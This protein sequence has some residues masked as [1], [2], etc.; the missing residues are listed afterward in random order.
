ME[1]A[2]TIEPILLL[3]PQESI[4]E[5]KRF[6]LSTPLRASAFPVLS[7]SLPYPACNPILS[8][9]SFFPNFCKMDS[10]NNHNAIKNRCNTF[11]KGFESIKGYAWD[12]G[13]SKKP[14]KKGMDEVL[15][16]SP[17]KIV[18]D[19]EIQ[20]SYLYMLAEVFQDT[21]AMK[22]L[23]TKHDSML[24]PAGRE[25]L[26]FWEQNPAFWC[27]FSVKEN[28][29]GNFHQIVDHMS[30]KEHLL[31][32][33]G[34]TTM[35]KWK[36]AEGLSFLCLMQPNGECLQTV[37][38]IKY[39]RLPASDVLFY[40]AQFKPEEGLKDILHKHF[41]QFFT[42]DTI[43]YAPPLKRGIYKMGFAW[44]AFTLPEFSL[45]NLGGTWF[46]P[47]VGTH[48]KF[49][50]KTVDTRMLGLPNLAVFETEPHAMAGAIIRDNATDEMALLTN[51]EV[52]YSFFSALLSRAYPTIKLPKEPSIFIG[53]PMQVLLASLDLPVPWKKFEDII[54]YRE[55]KEKVE[56]DQRKEWEKLR[57]ENR[58]AYGPD[59][60]DNSERDL[61]DLFIEAQ[62]TGKPLD[63]DKVSKVMGLDRQD[64]QRLLGKFDD[65]P[66]GADFDASD[67]EEDFDFS[68][69]DFDESYEDI[70]FTVPDEDKVFELKTWPMPT[71][72]YG[73]GVYQSLS[74]S[75]F[76]ESNDAEEAYRQFLQL[77]GKNFATE[78]GKDGLFEMVE[79]L[80]S[81]TFYENFAYPVMN[82][83]FWI[84]YHEGKEW[85][86]VRSY[87]IEILKWIPSDILH[88]YGDQEV[89]IELLGKFIK[90]ML[91]TRGICSLAK[92][93]SSEEIRSGTYAIKATDAFYSLLKVKEE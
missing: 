78:V 66:E 9:L 20:L 2:Y 49:T 37:G 6:R 38:V 19:N 62:I 64:V 14:I 5:S 55:P 33:K 23:R 54:D 47:T 87:A 88:S 44:Q 79:A 17:D 72:T 29:G 28:L 41:T 60:S 31:Y 58:K 11:T 40:C 24:T 71:D 75:E 76:F 57:E 50:L 48:Q 39:Y 45:E 21:K 26:S 32:S 77:G 63:A 68:D 90:R 18:T 73:D 27:Y 7:I 1:T 4:L 13:H 8:P 36:E 85:V 16:S 83:F 53:L 61:I 46:S 15:L 12:W 69:D 56:A 67:D 43:G 93:P 10:M 52:A 51:T 59:S 89:F 81:E 82:T 35:Q 22:Q 80:F 92:R 25:V 30:G 65:L 74:D 42:L 70:F 86:P 91:C 34:I 3:L 84:L